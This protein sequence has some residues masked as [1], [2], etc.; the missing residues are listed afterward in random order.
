[1]FICC[2][3]I[4]ESFTSQESIQFIH[5]KLKTTNDLAKILSDL[6]TAVVDKGSQVDLSFIPFNELG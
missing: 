6:L 2:D 1:M 4:F 3:G 5:E